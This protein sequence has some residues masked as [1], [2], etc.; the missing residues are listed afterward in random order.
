MDLM[1]ETCVLEWPKQLIPSVLAGKINIRDP[2]GA[3][4][5]LPGMSTDKL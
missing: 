5:E 1:R 2:I 3:D 4:F